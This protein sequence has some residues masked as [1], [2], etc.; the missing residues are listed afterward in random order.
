MPVCLPSQMSAGT[1]TYDAQGSA[2]AS[3]PSQPGKSTSGSII[4]LKKIAKAPLI[5]FTPD[6]SSSQNAVLATRKR[7]AKLTT[8]AST[9]D[10]AKPSAAVGPA[11]RLMSKNTNPIT[12][13]PI[14]RVRKWY[15][16]RPRSEAR[17]QPTRPTGR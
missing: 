3:V 4:P 6:W 5:T 10:T 16:A 11:G 8:T 14:P 13:G 15:A 1:C 9:S 12:V 17:Y 2:L 7:I